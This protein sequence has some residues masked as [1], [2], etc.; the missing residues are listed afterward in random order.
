MAELRIEN[1]G[2]SFAGRA[3]LRDVS[4]TVAAGSL[5]AILGPS[6]GGKTTLLR[7]ICGFDLPDQGQITLDGVRVSATGLHVLTEQ[8][9]IGY[10]PQE[11]ALFP[12]LSVADNIVFG[13]PL[14]Q[15]RAAYRVAELLE[16]VGLPPAWAQRSP[17]QLSGGEQQRVALARALAPNPALVLLDEPFSGLDAGLR[18]ETRQSLAAALQAAHA[19]ALLVTHDQAEAFAMGQQVAILWGGEMLQTAAPQQVYYQPANRDVAN[20]VGEAVWLDGMAQAGYAHCA[21]GQLPLANAVPDGPV[22][23]LLRPEQIRASALPGATPVQAW[24]EDILFQGGDTRLTV[25]LAD[26]SRLGARADDYR[27]LRVGQA[28]ALAVLGDPFAYAH[29]GQGGLHNP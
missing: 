20:F 26:G 13:L 17:Q 4:L 15:R 11:G 6:G 3:V 28:V 19:T 23:L 2:K 10:V 12:Y 27:F 5:T 29:V 21:L 1:L 16:M 18:V 24:V 25:R 8:R 9:R 14:A 7:L 22:Q